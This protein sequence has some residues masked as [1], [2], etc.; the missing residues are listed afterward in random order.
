MENLLARNTILPGKITSDNSYGLV[1]SDLS[2]IKEPLANS[3]KFG[4]MLAYYNSRPDIQLKDSREKRISY[5]NETLIDGYII[6]SKTVEHLFVSAVIT[7]ETPGRLPDGNAT[8]KP[9]FI[10]KK[11]IK[12]TRGRITDDNRL[13]HYFSIRVGLETGRNE[14]TLNCTD[15][16]GNAA[17][18]LLINIIRKGS[19]FRK[20]GTR[21]K[22]ALNYFPRVEEMNPY[23]RKEQEKGFF[24]IIKGLLKFSPEK[25]DNTE[26]ARILS[27]GFEHMLIAEMHK[28][29]RFS[30][31]ELGLSQRELLD[32]SKAIEKG[33]EQGIDCMLIGTVTEEKWANSVDISAK[34]VDTETNDILAVEDV[35]DEHVDKEKLR[36]L[37]HELE[38]KLTDK[39][40]LVEGRVLKIRG[41]HI[42]VDIG[43]KKKIQEGMKLIV[44]QANESDEKELGNA[45]IRE[46]KN[47]ESE[48]LLD[49]EA[50]KEAIKPNQFVITR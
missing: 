24:T 22:L 39:L 30:I 1:W 34:L 11:Q 41:K 14:F 13:K 37:S 40:P 35:Y 42:T 49:K 26:H 6:G 3:Q 8:V 9:R 33:K 25:S 29:E 16:D 12:I 36:K 47:E 27:R 23:P 43:R 21:L 2:I 46:V 38:L 4:H 15:I 44:Y 10:Q 28:R 5:L 19:E 18:P 32:D 20:L 7:P 31:R 17:I 48:A 50:D 45:R